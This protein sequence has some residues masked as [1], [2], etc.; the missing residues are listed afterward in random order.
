VDAP[1]HCV[2]EES[3]LITGDRE[4]AVSE[5]NRHVLNLGEVNYIDSGDGQL[6]ALRIPAERWRHNQV[7]EPD[8][9]R[10]RSAAITKLLRFS[11]YTTPRRKP[12]NPSG[13]PPKSRP[14]S[15]AHESR[16]VIRRAWSGRSGLFSNASP[17]HFYFVFA[18]SASGFVFRGGRWR[19]TG[20]WSDI[21]ASLRPRG[22]EVFK[23]LLQASVVGLGFG[24]NLH[25]FRCRPGAAALSIPAGDQLRA[26][27]RH[28]AGRS[29]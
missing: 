8:Q 24:M 4:K 10:G 16:L 5:N 11:T 23:Y 26:G 25:R 2:G 22:E 12:S 21:A 14:R 28:G 20:V 27:C 1:A 15:G 3:S 9:A 6:V 17:H 13:R 29:A 18:V 7:N 19:L